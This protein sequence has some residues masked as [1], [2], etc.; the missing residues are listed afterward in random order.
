MLWALPAFAAA[1]PPPDHEAW[2]CR[3][4]APEPPA[5]ALTKVFVRLDGSTARVSESRRDPGA[6]WTVI[7]N[8]DAG[9]V[10]A[11]AHNGIEGDRL[12]VGAEILVIDKIHGEMARGRVFAR[13]PDKAPV[14]GACEIDDAPAPH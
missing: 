14:K 12:A 10:L 13:G 11:E 2:I 4:R 5:G 3:Y 8:T 1:S 9:A 7:S 6:P